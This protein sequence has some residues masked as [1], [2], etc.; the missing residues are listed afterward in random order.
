[1]LFLF[2]AFC[3]IVSAQQLWAQPIRKS[4]YDKIV[5]LAYEKLAEKDYYNAITKFEEAYEEREDKTF[6]PILADLNYLVRDFV[7]AERYYARIFRADKTNEFAA[8]RYFYAR[9]LKYNG[10]YEEAI[11]EFQKVLETA[12]KDS[13][14]TL[15]RNEISGAEMAME[16]GIANSD[17]TIGKGV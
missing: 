7:K 8:K 15:I 4:N 9:S 13:L 14:R 10:K 6:L 11:P 12:T 2:I 17:G 3:S 16:L 1:R 5:E